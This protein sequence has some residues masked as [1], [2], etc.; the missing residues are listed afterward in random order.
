MTQIINLRTRRKQAQRQTDRK[1]GSETAA[2]H[3]QSKAD[4]RLIAARA[5]RADRVLDGHLRDGKDS[6]PD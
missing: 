5:E 3:G 6:A 4:A 1:T 2:R